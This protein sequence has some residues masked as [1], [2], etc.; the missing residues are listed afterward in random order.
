MKLQLLLMMTDLLAFCAQGE[1]ANTESICCTMYTIDEVVKIIV[2][3]DIK[4]YRKRPFNR[5]LVWVYMSVE[6]TDSA[7]NAASLSVNK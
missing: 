4:L 3:P 6:Q 2:D 5:F 7:R 1:N